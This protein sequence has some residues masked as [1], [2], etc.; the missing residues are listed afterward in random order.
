MGAMGLPGDYSSQSRFVR[1][2][3]VKENS[4]CGTTEAE[5]VSQF[6]HI[7]RAVE[8]PR[9][10]VRLERGC[11]ISRYASCCNLDRGIYYYTTYE[12]SALSAVDL[13]REDLTGEALLSYPLLTQ[14]TVTMQ[15]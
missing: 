14:Q 10:S 12:N 2:A 3:F 7:L 8:Q 11:E 9:G 6:F 5:E 1:A 15:N 4:L 13:Y